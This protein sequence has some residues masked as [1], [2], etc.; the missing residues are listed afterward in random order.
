MKERITKAIDKLETRGIPPETGLQGVQERGNFYTLRKE[1]FANLLHEEN[2]ENLDY[3]LKYYD[4]EF[5]YSIAYQPICCP[6]VTL[7]S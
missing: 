4:L 3:K 1:L 2:I 7:T 5:L 6:P